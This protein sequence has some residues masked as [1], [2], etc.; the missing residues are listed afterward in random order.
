[1]V[2]GTCTHT[3]LLTTYWK[4]VHFYSEI[5]PN[6]DNVHVQRWERDYQ[7]PIP[8]PNCMFMQLVGIPVTQDGSGV[9]T[10]GD[11]PVP[12]SR[13]LSWKSSHTDRRLLT[14]PLLRHYTAELAAGEKASVFVFINNSEVNS[15]KTMHTDTCKHIDWINIFADYNDN[16]HAHNFMFPFWRGTP[17]ILHLKSSLLTINSCNL[18]KQLEN[19]LCGSERGFPGFEK[20]TDDVIRVFSAWVALWEM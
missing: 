4:I 2:C 1:M 13:A 7:A 15:H 16:A 10:T 19:V 12:P 11:V 6:P 9:V 20:I 18:Y 17:L 8:P 14:F 5:W 3:D